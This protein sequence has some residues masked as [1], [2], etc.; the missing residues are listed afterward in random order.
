[1]HLCLTD[2]QVRVQQEE[3]AQQHSAA[4]AAAAAAQRMVTPGDVHRVQQRSH[5]SIARR[6][7]LVAGKEERMQRRSLLQAQLLAQVGSKQRL[8]ICGNPCMFSTS[9]VQV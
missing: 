4:A 5:D 9:D 7:S 8:H 3:E 1:M 6:N 2:S